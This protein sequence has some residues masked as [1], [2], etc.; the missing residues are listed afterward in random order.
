LHTGFDIS[1]AQIYAAPAYDRAPQDTVGAGFAEKT[2][3]EAALADRH[4]GSR[5]VNT[6]LKTMPTV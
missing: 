5:S 1:R 2:S 6:F 4:E 3:T